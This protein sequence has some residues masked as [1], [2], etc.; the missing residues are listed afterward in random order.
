MIKY[1]IGID[2]GATKI[3]ARITPSRTE[4]PHSLFELKGGSCSISNNF[5][6]AVDV[7]K[8]LVTQLTQLVDCQ[9]HQVFIAIGAAGAG[10]EQLKKV[11]CEQLYQKLNI[12]KDQLLVTTD[13]ITSIFGA[14]N[15]DEAVCLALGT[16]SVAISLDCYGKTKQV[17]GWGASISDEGGAFFI[18]KQAVRAAL[19][20]YD[21]HGE[22]AAIL[23]LKIS[24]HIGNTRTEILSWLS[25]AK[26]LDFAN[27]APLVTE[28]KE[29]CPLAK[30]V[31]Q[32]HI[33]QV[34]VLANA[35]LYNKNVPLFLTGSLAEISAPYLSK[36]LQKRLHPSKG[37][38]IDGACL[39]AKH[40]IKRNQE[41]KT[42]Q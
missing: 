11:F 20:D 35:A 14:N 24:Q 18:G 12:N 6:Q 27:L 31:F 7:V 22:F 15:G 30:K 25:H 3:I 9:S 21:K 33:K 13:A 34:E 38:S 41:F 1:I 19:W 29:N 40:H 16:G 37:N 4:N 39:L 2:G 42:C 5:E 17:G 28:L 26:P 8:Q 10:N 23:S 32:E 36:P